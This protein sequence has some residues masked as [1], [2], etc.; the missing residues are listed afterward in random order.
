MERLYSK[1]SDGKE[2]ND[3]VLVESHYVEKLDGKNKPDAI[4]FEIGQYV[5]VE[6]PDK[7]F[8]FE[9]DNIITVS[10]KDARLFAHAILKLCD[11]IE[12]FLVQFYF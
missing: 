2:E 11:E 5:G 1:N 3:Y 12:S 10:T 8:P 7:K 6:Q 4:M 9:I